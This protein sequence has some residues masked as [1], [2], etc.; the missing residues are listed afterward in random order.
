MDRS[1]L[2][3]STRAGIGDIFR[4]SDSKILVPFGK[5]FVVESVIKAEVLTFR[6]DIL[7]VAASR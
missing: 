1:F 6:E 7:V 5:E 2:G 4:D 3:C